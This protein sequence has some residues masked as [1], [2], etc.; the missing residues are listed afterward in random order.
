MHDKNGQTEY[1]LPVYSPN[2]KLAESNIHNTVH[3]YLTYKRSM[4]TI[5]VM[6]KLVG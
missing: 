2:K 6:T 3:V 5:F 1:V 4:S